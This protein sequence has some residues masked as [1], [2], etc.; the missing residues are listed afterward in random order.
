[1]NMRINFASISFS[2]FYSILLDLILGMNIFTVLVES[3]FLF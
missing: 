2:L 3:L 1:M